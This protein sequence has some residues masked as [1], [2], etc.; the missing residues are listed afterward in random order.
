MLVCVSGVGCLSGEVGGE[1][2]MLLEGVGDLADGFEVL[3]G[4]GV[5][6]VLGACDGGGGVGGGEGGV[7][8]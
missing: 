2:V 5:D 7:D 1:V 8:L 6:G 3:P 4:A